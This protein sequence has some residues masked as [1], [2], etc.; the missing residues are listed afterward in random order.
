MTPQN[1]YMFDFHTDLGFWNL[2]V[3]TF[4]FSLLV[5]HSCIC[6]KRHANILHCY[7]QILSLCLLNINILSLELQ[8]VDTSV[9]GADNLDHNWNQLYEFSQNCLLITF[10]FM[11]VSVMEHLNKVTVWTQN[12]EIVSISLCPSLSTSLYILALEHHAEFEGIYTNVLR[13]TYVL[14]LHTYYDPV[15]TNF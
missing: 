2:I 7:I 6:A 10:D 11:S 9:D 3:M 12:H 13:W 8:L 15:Y 5:S 1:S 14:F 4:N